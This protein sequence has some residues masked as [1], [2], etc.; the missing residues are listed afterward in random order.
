M[1][2]LIQATLESDILTLSFEDP[3][4]RNS[5]SLRAAREVRAVWQKEAGKYKGL[6]FSPRGRVFCS[7]GNLSDYAAMKSPEEGKAVNREIAAILKELSELP[8]P[9]LCLVNGDCF[10]GGLELL[11]AFDFVHSVPHALFG[12]WQR[13]IGLSFGWGGGERLERRLGSQKLRA[14]ALSAEVFSAHQALQW[15]LIDRVHRVESLEQVARERL[16]KISSL[17]RSPTAS[18]KKWSAESEKEIF[19][20]LWWNEEHLAVL[21]KFSAKP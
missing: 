13:K 7:G 9:T 5:F 4:S 3:S 16:E 1:N 8:V 18:L 21:S 12:L 15:G 20:T 14:L 6:V 17:P 19:E 2:S 11:S 10:G